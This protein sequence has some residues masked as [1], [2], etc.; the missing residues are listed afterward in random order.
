LKNDRIPT[1]PTAQ[2]EFSGSHSPGIPPG[3]AEWLAGRREQFQLADAVDLE[4]LEG[5]HHS[6]SQLHEVAACADFDLLD[7]RC[8]RDRSPRSEQERDP[9]VL[10]TGVP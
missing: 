4:G 8:G 3:G 10:V 9:A 5:R 6:F 2:E 7:C 1:N